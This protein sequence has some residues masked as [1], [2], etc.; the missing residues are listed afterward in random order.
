M[1]D[2]VPVTTDTQPQGSFL[3]MYMD[4][5]MGLKQTLSGLTVTDLNAKEPTPRPVPVWFLNPEREERRITYPSITINFTGERVAHEREHRGR[6]QIFY[7][8]LQ[9][10]P[11]DSVRP[12]M[13]DYP[14]PM[15]LDYQVTIHTR[16]N[17]H[18]T[19][20]N[21]LLM[22]GPLHPRFGYVVCPGGTIRRLEVLAMTTSN[23]QESDK[24]IFRHLFQVRIP[25]EVEASV[26]IGSRVQ[27]VALTVRDALNGNP[28]SAPKVTTVATG[29]QDLYASSNAGAQSMSQPAGN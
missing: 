18:I 6:V 13:I 19:Q 10:I 4:E 2:D 28:F 3:G 22:Q 11:F 16:I 7:H 12:P 20:L 1:P 23:G 14:I 25:T 29:I 21:A 24:R 9:D 15:D 27:A 5:D 17:Q 8:Y 26:A